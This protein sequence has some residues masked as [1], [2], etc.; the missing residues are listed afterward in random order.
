M[1][2]VDEILTGAVLARDAVEL[3]D[4]ALEGENAPDYDIILK[5]TPLRITISGE[6]PSWVWN[7]LDGISKLGSFKPN[8]DTY[9]GLP[10][11]PA[12]ISAGLELLAATMGTTTPAPAVVPTSPG[13]IQFEWHEAGVDL[14]LEI[15]P[16]GQAS[17]VFENPGDD[18]YVEVDAL[19]SLSELQRALA[20][21]SPNAT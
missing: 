6:E 13:G 10:V 16:R 11:E 19:T 21:L 14:E 3:P 18:E 4:A 20:L 7:V 1:S 8:W 12:S 15:S 2:Y 5:N 9:G 17:M